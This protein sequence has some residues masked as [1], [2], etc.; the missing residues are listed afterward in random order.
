MGGSER[1]AHAGA[2]PSRPLIRPGPAAPS[3]HA[4]RVLLGA[5]LETRGRMLTDR[6][7]LAVEG[8]DV[9]RRP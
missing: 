5:A 3:G 8:L 4:A 7:R 6:R 1:Q 2:S 9:C